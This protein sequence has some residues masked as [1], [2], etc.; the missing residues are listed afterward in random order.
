MD[1]VATHVEKIKNLVGKVSPSD[2]ATRHQ[3][4]EA[5]RSLVR[6][7]ETPRET[8]IKHCWA[9]PA[10]MT[11]LTLGVDVGL[12]HAMAADDGSSKTTA[13][14]AQRVGVE[15]PVIRQDEYKPTGFTTALCI[16]SISAGYPVLSGGL[17]SANN[18]FHEFMRKTNYKMPSSMTDGPLQYAYNTKLNMFEH[19]Q[20]NPPYGQLFNDHMA[21]YRQGRASWMDEGVFPVKER[22]IDGF[23]GNDGAAFLVDIG[24]SI[25]HDIQEFL[26]KYPSPPGR[27]ILQDLPV[28][29]GQIKSLDEK[30]ERMGYD[31]TTEQPV[32]GSRAYYMHSVLHD[33]PDETCMKILA[34]ITE[35]MTPGYSKLLINENVIPARG[36]YW[37]ST[38]LD[39]LMMLFFTSKERTEQDWRALLGAAGLK[40]CKIWSAGE[41][42][43]SLIEC[44]LL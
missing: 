5:A 27:L 30:I 13:D 40:I 29:I 16:P 38:A 39:V 25:G 3:L 2:V 44:E 21:G 8:M 17:L 10:A 24:G 31:F 6:A 11:A 32:K 28:V 41:G 35:A 1:S 9:Q 22:L 12:F 23:E 18:K 36:A 4:L 14:L 26:H 7:L 43:E 15:T 37:E 34:R 42:V 33:W 19:L 20:A